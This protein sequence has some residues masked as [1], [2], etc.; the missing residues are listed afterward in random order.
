MLE[1]RLHFRIPVNR[2][3]LMTQN[4]E[5]TVCDILDLTEQGLQLRTSIPLK[6]G[7]TV[8]IE[9]QL[10]TE[11]LIHCALRILHADGLRAGG[12]MAGISLDDHR[13]LM[14]FLNEQH[15]VHR[16]GQ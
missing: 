16:A 7:D 2:R 3:G 12:R 1:Q 10:G 11:C 6:A 13:H 9:C 15:A 4:E 8:Q 5:T 14:R